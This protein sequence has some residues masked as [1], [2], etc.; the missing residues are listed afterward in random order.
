MYVGGG[1]RMHGT[2]TRMLISGPSRPTSTC[3]SCHV[4][5]HLPFPSMALHLRVS[6]SNKPFQLH[7]GETWAWELF[8]ILRDFGNFN[9]L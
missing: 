9:M 4:K 1:E 2:L 8:F 6:V 5:L 7:T 3:E